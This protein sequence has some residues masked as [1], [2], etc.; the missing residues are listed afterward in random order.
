VHFLHFVCQ[1]SWCARAGLDV[2]ELSVDMARLSHSGQQLAALARTQ[3]G[4]VATWQLHALGISNEAARARTRTGRLHR[5]HRGVYAVGHRDLSR[6]GRWMAAVLAH[7]PDAVLSHWD[8][9][10]LW[11]LRPTARGAVHVT[12]PA[13]GR[14]ASAA[15]QVH[16]VRGLDSRDLTRLNGIPVTSVDRTLLDL[17]ELASPQELRLALEAADRRELLDGREV[18]AVIARNPGRHGI[19]RLRA[20]LQTLQGPPPWTQSELERHF[21]AF[22]RDAG[23]PEPQCNVVIG[24]ELV[25]MVWPQARLV[26]ELDGYGSHA[27]RAQFETDRRRDTR[28]LLAGYRVVRIT[29]RRLQQEPDRVRAELEALIHAAA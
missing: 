21:L 10:A 18:D 6:H 24:G 13:S 3:H 4:V 29:Q 8:A 23:L 12:V 5:I 19:A 15:I 17:A 20:A 1:R 26:V 7:G 16:N 2:N 11:S 25:D 14:R 28:L 9:A 22:V 27:G